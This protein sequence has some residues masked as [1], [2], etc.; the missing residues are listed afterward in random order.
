MA[1]SAVHSEAVVLLIFIH[2]LLFIHCGAIVFGPRF[3]MQYFVLFLVLPP[4]RKE[5]HSWLIDFYCLAVIVIYCFH[6]M[7]WVG[8]WC[9]N[10]A[11]PCHTHLLYVL[12]QMPK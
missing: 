8:L 9:M 1:S 7:P 4:S 2:C 10:V 6:T 3:V 12:Q 11:F 5:K